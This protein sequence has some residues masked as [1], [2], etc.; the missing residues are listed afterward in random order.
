MLY[1]SR[2]GLRLNKVVRGY[3]DDP[4]P[5]IHHSGIQPLIENSKVIQNLDAIF[6][7]PFIR[8]VQTAHY[9]N[10][11]DAPIYIEYG[12][13]ETLRAKWFE[14][15]GYNPLNRLHNSH[16][17]ELHYYNVDSEY[18]SQISQK[19]P[20]SRRDSRKRVYSFIE[21]LKKSEYW[22]KDVL[23]IGHG[24]SIKDCLNALGINPPFQGWRRSYPAMGQ[25]FVI[26]NSEKDKVD[27]TDEV[28][29][30]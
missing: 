7:S 28:N 16:D 27:L 9:L 2:H 4:N 18:V 1:L 3:N 14:K 22:E 5:P 23:L 15:A 30:V 17:L 11:H 29:T 6:C 26:D 25:L 8:C 19:F 13:S 21:W 12:L 20:E 24:F 10:R